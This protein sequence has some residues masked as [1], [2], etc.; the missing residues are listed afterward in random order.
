MVFNEKDEYTYF[1]FIAR[2]T[3]DNNGPVSNGGPAVS[4]RGDKKN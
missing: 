4:T 3:N 2:T 1:T